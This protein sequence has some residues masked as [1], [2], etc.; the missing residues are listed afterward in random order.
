M[1]D[2]IPVSSPAANAVVVSD[3]DAQD[4]DTEEDW[5]LVELKFQLRLQTS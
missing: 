3:M 1:F 5:L 4:I 2:A